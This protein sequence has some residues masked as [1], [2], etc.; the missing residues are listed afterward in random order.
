VDHGEKQREHGRYPEEGGAD[1]RDRD[2][3]VDENGEGEAL[4]PAMPGSAL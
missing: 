4:V 1:R 2:D 3:V